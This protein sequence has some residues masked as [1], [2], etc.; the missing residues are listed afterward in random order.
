M[1]KY[2]KPQSKVYK[3]KAESPILTGSD[4]KPAAALY[5]EYDSTN[6]DL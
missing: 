5:D 6:D 4:V 3:V 1:K 2:I